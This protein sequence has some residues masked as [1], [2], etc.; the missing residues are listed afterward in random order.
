MSTKLIQV[1]DLHLE[2]NPDFRI[3][4]TE[5][6]DWLNLGGDICVAEYFTRGENS[7]KRE[8][9]KRWLQF[10]ETASREFPFI[11]YILGNHESYHGH[12]K[13]SANILREALAHLPNINIL[14]RE[15]LDYGD[16]RI[17]GGTLWTDVSKRNPL[18]L[19]ALQGGLNDFSLIRYEGYK[20]FRP[21]ESAIL[22]AKTLALFKEGYKPDKKHVFL[23]HHAP[24]Y[25]SIHQDY[26]SGRYSHLNSGYYSDLDEFI[27]EHPDIALWT[28]GHV[29]SNFDYRIGSTRVVCN[30]H[31][32]G[33]ENKA[34]FEPT[35]VIELD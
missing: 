11:T 26:R 31:G 23:S 18:A 22:H 6:A 12:I 33:A 28:H 13:E 21:L 30:P 19:N 1:S 8:L 35:G 27:L 20:K 34:G 32:Y 25:Q 16:Y 5:K 4:N 7:P 17:F 3:Y 29:H 24:S 15:F 14:D 9:T 10:F 2:F